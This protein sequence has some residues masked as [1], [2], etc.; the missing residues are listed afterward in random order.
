M[1]SMMNLELWSAESLAIYSKLKVDKSDLL[2]S[3]SLPV[4]RVEL[5]RNEKIAATEKL[6]LRKNEITNIINEYELKPEF[7]YGVYSL[8]KKRY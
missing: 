3:W 7:E 8:D 5:T 2:K 6:D 4:T 1:K